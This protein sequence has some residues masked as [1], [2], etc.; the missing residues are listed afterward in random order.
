MSMSSPESTD[1]RRTIRSPNP[2]LSV[3]T[4]TTK[5][6][7]RTTLNADVVVDFLGVVDF[8]RDGDLDLA[9]RALSRAIPF[10]QVRDS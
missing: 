2:P 4:G 8:D 10:S 1:A 9:A 7:Q 6:K 5:L 3:P